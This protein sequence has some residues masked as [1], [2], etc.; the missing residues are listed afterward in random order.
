MSAIDDAYDG[1]ASDE[2]WEI[3]EHCGGQYNWFRVEVRR[4][5]KKPDFWDWEMM[6]GWLH[7]D[8]SSSCSRAGQMTWDS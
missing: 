3:C 1:P 5:Q 4:V 6:Y 8:D 2:W 7:R